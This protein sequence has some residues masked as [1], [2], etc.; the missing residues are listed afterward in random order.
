[1]LS[2]RSYEADMPNWNNYIVKGLVACLRMHHPS[3]VHIDV[4][5]LVVFVLDTI[6]D[7]LPAVCTE[8][9]HQ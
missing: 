5:L 2:T 6:F 3:Q 8:V 7:T 1:M 4:C 9:E